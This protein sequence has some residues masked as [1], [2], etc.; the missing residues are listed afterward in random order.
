MTELSWQIFIDWDYAGS[1]NFDFT[2]PADD[3]S[4]YVQSWSIQTGMQNDKAF[5]AGVGTVTLQLFNADKRFSPAN[6]LGPYYGRLTLGKPV[7]IVASDGTNTWTKYLGFIRDIVAEGGLAGAM[8]NRTATVKCE[9]VIGILQATNISLPLFENVTGDAV[10]KAAINAALR[11]PQASATLTMTANPA[12]NDTLVVNGTTITFKT[13]LTGAA[14]EVQIGPD[15]ASTADRLHRFINRAAGA[16]SD[17]SSALTEL[18]ITSDQTVHSVTGYGSANQDGYVDL[19]KAITSS[20]SITCNAGTGAV[21][22]SAGAN[23]GYGNT[24]YFPYNGGTLDSIDVVFAARTGSPVGTVTWRLY[25]ASGNTTPTS[26]VLATGTFIPTDNAS[27]HVAINTALSAAGYYFISF[28][29]TSS[30]AAGNYWNLQFSTGAS[31]YYAS[32]T[33]DGGGTWTYQSGFSLYFQANFSAVPYS[34]LAQRL[35]FTMPS[36]IKKLRLWAKKTGAPV[37]TLTVKIETENTSNNPSGTLTNVNAT[38]TAAESGLGAGYGWVTFTLPDTVA[39]QPGYYWITLQTSRAADASNYVTWGCDASSPT[40]GQTIAIYLLSYALSSQTFCFDCGEEILTLKSKLRGAAGNAYT[41]TKSSSGFTLSGATLSGGVD[42]PLNLLSIDTG[43]TFLLTAGDKWSSDKTNALTVINQLTTTEQG[44]FYCAGDGTLVWENRDHLYMPVTQSPAVI[45]DTD[46]ATVQ[47]G[48][49]LSELANRVVVNYTPRGYLVSGVVAKSM[50]VITVPPYGSNAAAAGERYNAS[51]VFTD[52][53]ATLITLPFIDP[54]TGQRMGAK[55]LILPL[56]SGTDLHITDQADGLG[57]NYSP[58]NQSMG[59][60]VAITANGCEIQFIN[61]ATGNLYVDVLQVRGIGIVAYNAQS[62]TVED[63]TAQTTA[64]VKIMTVDLPLPTDATYAK[65]LA[66]YL[67]A[68][69]KNATYRISSLG[70]GDMAGGQG[71]LNT[72]LFALNLGD[73]AAISDSQLGINTQK[74]RIIGMNLSVTAQKINRVSLV[75]SRTDDKTF[76]VLGHA[77]YGKLGST[78][79]LAI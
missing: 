23:Q 74:Y 9:D 65:G 32:R 63:E 15:S 76:W 16:G 75:V 57:Y 10:V 40:Y 51:D 78:T 8:L 54:A 27:N 3:I 46:H 28:T 12:N 24:F 67:L 26:S 30:Q 47:G 2:Q 43:K 50:S 33:L 7:K 13:T 61:R 5:V 70:F 38:A 37:G 49:N 44:R 4:D 6:I 29:P 66:Q 21:G 62:V 64:G 39:L 68:R 56:V 72:N 45:I 60:S 53:N 73:I 48:L 17:Y 71:K 35:A 69:N 19:N 41:L 52:P 55:S 79:R 31:G 58:P 77:T 14:N 42:W 22:Y 36:A 25:A 59:I 34:I 20:Q 18:P 1:W 11:A